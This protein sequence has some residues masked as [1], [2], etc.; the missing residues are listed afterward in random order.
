MSATGR[1]CSVDRMPDPSG[2]PRATDIN[3]PARPVWLGR[4]TDVS[5]IPG[6]INEQLPNLVA[7]LLQLSSL[8]L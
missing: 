7:E 6:A 5:P 4:S 1:L 3:R 8:A 2:L